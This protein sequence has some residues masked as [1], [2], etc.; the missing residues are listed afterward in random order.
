MATPRASGAQ[1]ARSACRSRASQPAERAHC[2]PDAAEARDH[3]WPRREHQ[4]RSAR[5]RRVVREHRSLTNARTARLM[6]AERDIMDGHA[7]SIRG[8][9]PAAGGFL[10]PWARYVRA[11]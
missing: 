8:E 7:A 1:C 3:G 10:M 11:L 5:V 4:A 6:L 2:P 9:K